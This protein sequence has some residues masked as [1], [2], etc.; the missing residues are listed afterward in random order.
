VYELKASAAGFCPGDSV[1]FALSN[2]ASGRVYRL[3]KGSTPV[4][5]L[6]TGQDAAAT[7]TGAFA[8][9]GTYTARVD[10]DG[11]HCPAAMS[12]TLTITANA[13]PTAPTIAKPADV[14][15][16]GD[17][18]VFT[19]TGYSGALT[20]TAVTTGG[21]VTGSSVTYASGAENGT[22]TVTAR[23][24]QTYN[25]APACKSSEVQ[26]TAEVYALPA[27]PT[28]TVKTGSGLTPATFTASDGS[29]S[30]NW[31]GYF[32]GQTEAVLHTPAEEGT[33]TAAVQ[34][35]EPHDYLVCASS[36]TV[37]MTAVVRPGLENGTPC[38]T[39]NQ[40]SGGSC[41][42]N[43]CTDDPNPCREN[44]QYLHISASSSCPEDYI[45]IDKCADNIPH[46]WGYH[47]KVSSTCSLY[48]SGEYSHTAYTCKGQQIY[49]S[50]TQ[51]G[52]CTGTQYY[53]LCYKHL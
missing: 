33:Y 18:L 40:C 27:I 6:T 10:A 1:T 37:P 43:K 19:A 7:F 32:N 38:S 28:L 9:A 31:T 30:Y 35:E 16:N 22:K 2:A 20:W 39:D 21:T 51:G 24:S 48:G 13:L 11:T 46:L 49:S 8:G 4:D 25:G 14:C 23:S 50:T 15:Y 5:E 41:R 12:G 3:Y 52:A 53:A 42:C 29:G 36:Y 34:S 47:W 45:R 44:T 17:A 26:Q